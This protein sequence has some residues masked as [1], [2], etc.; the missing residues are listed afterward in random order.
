MVYILLTQNVVFKILKT[1]KNTNYFWM[2]HLI[3]LTL[4]TA[5]VWTVGLT[6]DPAPKVVVASS[7]S[8]QQILHLFLSDSILFFPRKWP[9]HLQLQLV[10]LLRHNQDQRESDVLKY[11]VS[12][13]FSAR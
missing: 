9:E 7:L 13:H 6:T 2:E 4:I 5:A 3:D 1:N 10:R 8:A 11:V 12:P